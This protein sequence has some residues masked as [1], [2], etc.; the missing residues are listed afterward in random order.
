MMRVK[1]NLYVCLRSIVVIN[2]VYRSFCVNH[3]DG[4]ERK[5]QRGHRRA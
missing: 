4:K 3:E 5:E 1:D 2:L